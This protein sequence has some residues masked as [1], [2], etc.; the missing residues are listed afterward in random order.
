MFLRYLVALVL[1]LA[2]TVVAVAEDPIANAKGRM[3]A[4][5]KVYEGMLK[6][7]QTD[8]AFG[9]D[10]ERVNRWSRRWLDAEKD[11]ANKKDDQVAAVQA[12]LDRMKKL[13]TQ[14]R[15]MH[16]AGMITAVDVAACEF[17]RLEAE[18]MLDEAKGK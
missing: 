3:E 6:R 14:A 2:L 5:Q 8:P 12:H 13:E 16:K 11:Y 9:F 18:K 1:T 4:A 10:A 17:Y 15:L 7:M